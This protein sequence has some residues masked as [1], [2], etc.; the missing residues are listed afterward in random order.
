L[1]AVLCPL[2]LFFLLSLNRARRRRRLSS[3]DSNFPIDTPLAPGYL[4][5]LSIG[6]R[7][8]MPA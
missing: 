5:G 6:S 2:S 8:P 4:S 1:S 7:R 3:I